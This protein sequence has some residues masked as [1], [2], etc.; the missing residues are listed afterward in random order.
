M[1]HNDTL[2]ANT[3]DTSGIRRYAIDWQD[4]LLV[5]ALRAIP[6]DEDFP[7]EL[8][9]LLAEPRGGRRKTIWLL[10][11]DGVPIAVAPL[12]QLSSFSWQPVTQ[13]ILPG[14]VIPAIHDKLYPA[15]GALGR[16]LHI[17]SWGADCGVPSSSLVHELSTTVTYRMSCAEDFEAYWKSTDIW[18]SLRSAKNKSTHLALRENAPGA[19][20]WII[21]SWARKWGIAA[22]ETQDR[23]LAARFLEQRGKHFSL[24]LFDGDRPVAGQTC[25]SHRGEMIAQCLYRENDSSSLGNRMIHLTFCWAK[26]K[27]FRAIDIGGGYDYKRK[28]APPGGEEH[29]FIL[30]PRW[31]YAAEQALRGLKRRVIGSPACSLQGRQ[32]YLPNSSITAGFSVQP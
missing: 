10:T 19:S 1:A 31:R 17:A 20:E 14:V 26:E 24:T 28:F 12:R 8:I 18:R 6:E 7:H 3:R 30:A 5:E 11:Q 16:T 21:S 27:G 9:R 13:Y 23:I 15:L 25:L 2:R 32:Q 22:D 29:A 4:K